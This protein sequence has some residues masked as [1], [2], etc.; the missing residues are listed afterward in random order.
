M[1]VYQYE[2]SVGNFQVLPEEKLGIDGLWTDCCLR[3]LLILLCGYR[4]RR[5]AGSLSFDE[6]GIDGERLVQGRAHFS[7]W[8]RKGITYRGQLLE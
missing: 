7:D 8:S 2:V 5:L 4:K 3:T 1:Y 6:L